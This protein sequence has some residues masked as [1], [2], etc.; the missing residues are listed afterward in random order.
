MFK[1]LFFIALLFFSSLSH[2]ET[3]PAPSDLNKGNL[4]N[5]QALDINDGIPLS[6]ADLKRFEKKVRIFALAEY[7]PEAPE[8][9]GHCYYTGRSHEPDYLGVFLAKSNL[10]NDTSQGWRVAGG[11]TMQC[12]IGITQCGFH[13]ELQSS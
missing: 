5:W 2:A 9:T 1:K 3:C 11:K 7:M 6:D 8:G 10:I 12:D 4:H 13:D